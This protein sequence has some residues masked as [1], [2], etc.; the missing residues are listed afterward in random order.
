MEAMG[1]EFIFKI[2]RIFSNQRIIPGLV[3]SDKEVQ[4]HR[5]HT[6]TGSVVQTV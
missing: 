1:T 6:A 3:G 4:G 2:L 5:E